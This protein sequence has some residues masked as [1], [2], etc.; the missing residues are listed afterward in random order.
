M[1]VRYAIRAAD[2]AYR[3]KPSNGN[4]GNLE[5]KIPHPKIRHNLTSMELG[6]KIE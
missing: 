2:R 6:R 5:K 1:Y 3:S 4:D